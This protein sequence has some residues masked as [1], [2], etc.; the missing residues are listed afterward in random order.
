MTEG[1]VLPTTTPPWP[2][3]YNLAVEIVPIEHNP[4][5]QRSGHYLIHPGG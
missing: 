4:P 5:I 2:S 1:Q 3:L